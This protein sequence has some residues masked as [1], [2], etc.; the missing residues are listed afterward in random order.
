MQAN[1][2]E[3]NQKYIIFASDYDLPSTI[4]FLQSKNINFKQLKGKYKG[5]EEDSFIVNKDVEKLLKSIIKN[6]ESILELSEE[7]YNGTRF[8][9]LE[10]TRG[11]RVPLGYFTEAQEGDAKKQDG[12]T[13]DPTSN[14]YFIV[15]EILK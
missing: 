5:L 9:T 14:T 6:Q 7:R 4:E 11:E 10:I 12:Y 3:R 1:I 2:A 13:Y 15:K 8:A